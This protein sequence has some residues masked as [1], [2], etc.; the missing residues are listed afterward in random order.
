VFTEDP[1]E[2]A[3]KALQADIAIFNPSKFAVQEFNSQ[4]LK[5]FIKMSQEFNV[6]NPHNPQT[7]QEY[8]IVSSVLNTI[9]TESEGL[10]NDPD[11]REILS[12]SLNGLITGV[13]TAQIIREQAGKK[14]QDEINNALKE[15]MRNNIK[16][17]ESIFG[18]PIIPTISDYGM[19]P[20]PAVEAAIKQQ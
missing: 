18:E 11:R 12:T 20:Y 15:I 8:N 5:Q 7:Q 16:I 3:A 17:A 1:K 13:T 14:P 2:T 10:L 9:V 6:E 4:G 19:I